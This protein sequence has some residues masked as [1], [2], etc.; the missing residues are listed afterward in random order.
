M[1][2]EQTFKDFVL[3]YISLCCNLVS[4]QEQDPKIALLFQCGWA[5]FPKLPL[6]TIVRAVIWAVGDIV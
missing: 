4:R 6:Q 1:K 3:I 5:H 2:L